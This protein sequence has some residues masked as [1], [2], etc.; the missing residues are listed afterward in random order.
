MEPR[1]FHWP[2]SLFYSSLTRFMQ[3]G[4]RDLAERMEISDQAASLLDLGGG[5]G[6]LAIVIAQ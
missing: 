6:R 2:F 4:Y 1:E 3:A 5:D